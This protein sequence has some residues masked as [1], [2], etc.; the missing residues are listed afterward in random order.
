MN[1]RSRRQ[2]LACALLPFALAAM[3]GVR[4]EAAYP[5]HPIKLIVPFAAGSAADTLSRAVA[6]ALAE[7][8]GQPLVVDNK[9]GAGGTIGTMDIARAKPDGY[10]LGIAAQGTFVNNQVLYSA[11]GYDSIKDF[12]FISEIADVQNLLVVSEKSPY[13]NAKAL[14]DAIRSKPA[15]TFRYSSSGVG[16]SH[17]IAGAT[18]AKYLNKPLMHVPYTGAPQGLSAILSGDVDMGFY[19]LP[20]AIGLV[21]SGKLRPLAVTGPKRSALLPDVPTIAESGLKGY[22]VT[23]WWGL[24]GPAG[25]PPDVSTRLYG[26]LDKVM[27]NPALRDKLIGQ[28]FTLPDTPIPKPAAF[29]ELVKQDLAKWVPVLK[30]LGTAAQ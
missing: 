30:E 26:A 6:A 1:K 5:D 18:V 16:T 13:Q 17:H 20:A 7:Q 14:L 29:Q 25:L 2:A 22:S 21:K 23:L 8:L 24:V 11:P 9:G 4:A 3:W 28:G 15:E 10:T 12:S 27:S 19:N